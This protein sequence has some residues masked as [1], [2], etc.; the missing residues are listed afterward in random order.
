MKTFSTAKQSGDSAEDTALH[1]LQAQ[2]LRLV[3][4][5]YRTPQRRIIFAERTCLLRLNPLPPCRFDVVMLDGTV[6]LE[7]IKSAFDTYGY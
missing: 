7:W 5:N 3:Q 1:Y 6:K 2:G 4:R